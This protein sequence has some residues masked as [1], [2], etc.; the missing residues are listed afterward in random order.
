MVRIQSRNEYP[1]Y[2]FRNFRKKESLT[3]I[4]H[5]PNPFESIKDVYKEVMIKYKRAD[6]VE[7]SGTLY[8]PADYDRKAKTEKL[9]LL[10]WVYPAEYKD[11]SSAGQSSANPNEFTFPYYGSF[12]YWVTRGYAVSTMRLFPLLA[13]EKRNLTILLSNSWYP[14]PKRLL[15]R[16]IHSGLSTGIKW[17]WADILTGRL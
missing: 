17:L 8:L 9:P 12:V 14:M 1:N 2:Y 10:I 4:T 11:K 13:K 3:Q 16:L 15:M 6:G 7:L 5:F